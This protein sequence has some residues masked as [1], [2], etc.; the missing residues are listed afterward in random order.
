MFINKKKKL[1]CKCG[2]NGYKVKIECEHQDEYVLFK[3]DRALSKLNFI[4]YLQ[5]EKNLVTWRKFS[6]H[7]QYFENIRDFN[8]R[9]EYI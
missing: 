7:L 1:K 2:F 3:A 8:N 6:S 4:S 5:S 9:Q